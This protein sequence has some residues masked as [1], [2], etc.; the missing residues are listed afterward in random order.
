MVILKFDSWGEYNYYHSH[1]EFKGMH[2]TVSSCEKERAQ[3][4]KNEKQQRIL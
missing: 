3:I 1:G 2:H 4:F